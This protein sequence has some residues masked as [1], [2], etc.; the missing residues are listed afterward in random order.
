M[1]IDSKAEPAKASWLVDE[2]NFVPRDNVHYDSH[3][4]ATDDEVINLHRKQDS[5]NVKIKFL[6]VT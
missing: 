3:F 6:D 4:T 2:A 1:P 5:T